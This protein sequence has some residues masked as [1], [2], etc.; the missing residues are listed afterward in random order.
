LVPYCAIKREKAGHRLSQATCS[1]AATT[2]CSTAIMAFSN[3][4]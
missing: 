3:A 2:K 4:A 1:K